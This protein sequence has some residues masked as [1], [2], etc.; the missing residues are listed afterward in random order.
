MGGETRLR[1]F[2]T[3]PEHLPHFRSRHQ[4]QCASAPQVNSNEDEMFGVDGC[5]MLAREATLRAAKS[6][7]MSYRHHLCRFAR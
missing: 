2:R 7:N 4:Q 6:S 5:A 3:H 1:V